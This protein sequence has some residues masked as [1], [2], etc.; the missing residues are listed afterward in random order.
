[1]APGVLSVLLGCFYLPSRASYQ[2]VPHLCDWL[3]SIPDG[4]IG[5]VDFAASRVGGGWGCFAKRALTDG[6]ELFAIPQKYCLTTHGCDSTFAHIASEEG[7][8]AAL[9]SIVARE[10]LSSSTSFGAY[11]A[12]L[13]KLSDPSDDYPL[14]WSDAEVELLSG[15]TAHSECVCIR[16]EVAEVSARVCKT[17]G[18][19][20]SEVVTHGQKAVKEAMRT[21]YVSVLS[22]AF[23]MD[24]EASGDEKTDRH[25][26][27]MALIPILDLL[28]HDGLAPT[29]S[30]SIEHNENTGEALIVARVSGDQPAGCELSIT[31]GAHPDFVFGVHYAFVPDVPAQRASCYTSLRFDLLKQLGI[32]APAVLAAQLEADSGTIDPDD[33]WTAEGVRLSPEMALAALCDAAGTASIHPLQFGVSIEDLDRLQGI[34]ADH[35]SLGDMVS[36]GGLLTLSA[37]ARLCALREDG[38]AES[39]EVQASAAITTILLTGSLNEENDADAAILVTVAARTQL[40]L[41]LECEARLNDATLDDTVQP[42]ASCIAIAEKILESEKRI[43]SRLS[44]G[45]DAGSMF[46]IDGWAMLSGGEE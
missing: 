18:A 14:W 11:L 43:L 40:A 6:E 31:Y 41:L 15:T 10:A 21:A 29:V 44:Y 1:M 32:G 38:S 5:P 25:G 34:G 37:S 39:S 20:E 36:S 7:E 46:D 8:R 17:G 30:Y 9:A 28:Q 2:A 35:R 45:D 19:L 16:S 42:R 12:C 3:T 4:S 33:Q 23:T 22:R 24:F 26:S 13:P 27:A